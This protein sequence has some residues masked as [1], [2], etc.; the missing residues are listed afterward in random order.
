LHDFSGV[1]ALSFLK[2]LGLPVYPRRVVFPVALA[3]GASGFP[4]GF[5]SLVLPLLPR[6]G[7]RIGFVDNAVDSVSCAS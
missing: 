3:A 7:L 4:A 2:G 1:S 6:T 5:A